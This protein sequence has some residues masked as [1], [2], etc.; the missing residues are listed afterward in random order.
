M[1]AEGRNHTVLPAPSRV[2]AGKELDD[3][4]LQE[5][6][7]ISSRCFEDCKGPLL[8]THTLGLSIL[9]PGGEDQSRQICSCSFFPAPGKEHRCFSGSSF[10]HTANP[11]RSPS[12]ALLPPLCVLRKSLEMFKEHLLGLS[13]SGLGH[14]LFSPRGLEG[15]KAN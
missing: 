14:F 4:G 8:P 11:V 3:N 12:P 6:A 10:F 15:D 13:L 2:G 9:A 7:S 1:G 5:G